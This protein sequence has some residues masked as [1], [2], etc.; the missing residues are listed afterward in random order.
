M[1]QSAGYLDARKIHDLR[2]I[3]SGPFIIQDSAPPGLGVVRCPSIA[4]MPVGG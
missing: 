1:G 2:N 4:Q 3:H